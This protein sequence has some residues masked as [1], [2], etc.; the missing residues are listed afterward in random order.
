LEIA[1]STQGLTKIYRSP[2][3]GR[4]VKALNELTLEVL[5]GETLAIIGPNGSGKTTTLK[6]LLG[7]IY[8]TYGKAAI[9]GEDISDMKARNKIGYLPEEPYFYDCFTG[10]ELLDYYGKLFGLSAKVRRQRAG[11]LLALVGLSER[12]Q[13]P[14]REYSK[15][16]RQRAGLAQALVNDP[17]ILILDEPTSGLDPEGAYQM[18]RLIRELRQRGKTI[19]LCSHFLAQV[20]DLCDRVAMLNKG[21]L[22]ACGSLQDLVGETHLI[23]VVATCPGGDKLRTEL[24]ALAD[25]LEER[26]DKLFLELKT[27]SRL[28]PLID[29]LKANQGKIL[30][31][32]RPRP[33][34]EE[35]FIKLLQ[36][37]KE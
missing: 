21:E 2:L 29:C 31:I 16:M 7:L 10:R 27:E 6:L 30:E 34:L 32:V 37:G 14:L 22:R 13:T 33:S 35:L 4:G 9:L 8:P 28:Y 23:R 1:I 5:R 36:E 19:L 18:R 26:E 12:G 15:G 24:G 20:E 3:S 11:E 17:D 25:S